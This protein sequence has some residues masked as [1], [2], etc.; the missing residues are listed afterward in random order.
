MYFLVNLYLQYLLGF[1]LV[2]AASSLTSTAFY[3][4]VFVPPFQM[5][6]AVNTGFI[7]PQ[8]LVRPW[9]IWLYWLS[10]L[11]WGF[12]GL[13]INEFGGGIEFTCTADQLIPPASVAIAEFQGSQVRYLLT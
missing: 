11:K 10:P 2:F 5:I 7:I 4:S 6:L 1:A 12:E 8:E 13:I 3:P 9:W